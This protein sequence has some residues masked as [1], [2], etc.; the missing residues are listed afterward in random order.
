MDKLIH[1]ILEQVR[2]K[3]LSKAAACQLI[4]EIKEG[5]PQKAG[6]TGIGGTQ[7]SGN[8]ELAVI[9]MACRFPEADSP[10]AFWQN[11]KTGRDSITEFPGERWP[12][13]DFYSAGGTEAGKSYSKWGGFIKDIDKFA[14]SFFQLSVEEARIIDPQQRLFLEAALE[15]FA[16]AGYSKKLLW[17]TRTSVIVGARGATYRTFG[18]EREETFRSGMT[19]NITNFISA[20]VS[21]FFNLQGPSLTVDT[22]CS[23]SLV[24]VYYACQSIYNKECDMA[25][26]G[27]VELKVTPG[28]YITLSNAKALSPNGKSYVF[29]RRADGFVPGEGVG[30]VLIKP[31][32]RALEDGDS[33]YAVIKG[34]AVNNDGYTMGVTTPNVEGQKSVLRN[35]YKKAGITPETISCI[36]AHGTGTT[37]GDPIEMK[38]LT[39]VFRECTQKTGFCAVGSVKTNIGHLDTAAGIAGLIKVVL[40]LHH[41]QLPPTLN[42][43]IPNQRLNLLASPFYPN[44]YLRPWEPVEGVRRAGV[45]SFGFGGTN[46][47]IVLEE[48]PGRPAREKADR[49][50]NLLTLSAQSDGHLH[51]LVNSYA[52]HLEKRAGLSAADVCHTANTGREHF[53]CRLAVAASGEEDLLGKLKRIQ[54]NG[55]FSLPEKEPV[56]YGSKEKKKKCKIAFM[57]PGQGSQYPGMA[58]AL[59]QGQPVFREAMAECGD[60]LAPY[61]QKPLPEYIYGTEEG[62]SLL[63]ETGITQPAVFSVSYSLAKLWLSWGIKPAVVLGH[64]VGEYV[65]ACISGVFTLQEALRLIARRGRLMQELP[66]GGGMAVVFAGKREVL[67]YLSEL[68]DPER[69]RLSVAAE[70]GPKNTVVS[71]D[72]EILELFAGRL[73]RKNIRHSTLRVSHAFHSP[74]MEP[75]LEAYAKELDGVSFKD[76]KLPLIRNAD[77]RVM[78]KG[79][80]EKDYWLKHIMEPVLFETSINTAV[81]AGCDVLLEVGPG[82]TLASMVKQVVPPGG[83]TALLSTLDRRREE[84]QALIETLAQ[85]YTK[86]AD[87][88]F[89]GFDRHI[90]R[91]RVS[92]PAYSLERDSCWLEQRKIGA[93]LKTTA[94]PV[95]KELT[96]EHDD[97]LKDHV[98]Q[99]NCVLPGVCYWQMALEAGCSELAGPV[100]RL[101]EVMHKAPVKLFPGDAVTARISFGGNDG[102]EFR[103]ES[104]VKGEG[105]RWVE[106]A[107]GK[108]DTG[109]AGPAPE[110][111]LETVKAG[112]IKYPLSC[113]EVYRRFKANQVS[114]GPAFQS[115]KEIWGNER[116]ALARL[117]LPEQAGTAAKRQQ[118]FHPALMDG[119]LQSIIGIWTENAVTNDTYVPFFIE[120]IIFY[121][122]LPEKCYS[123][124]ELLTG[125]GDEILK[126]NAAIVDDCGRV[127]VKINGFTLKRVGNENRARADLS[128]RWRFYKPEW[129]EKS[130]ASRSEGTLTGC[131]LFFVSDD[132]FCGSV[133]KGLREKGNRVIA[134]RPAA[135]GEK[136]DGDNYRMNIS[137]PEDYHWLLTELRREKTEVKSYV[138]MLLHSGNYSGL[139]RPEELEE[140]LGMGVISLLHLVRAIDRHA[141]GKNADIRIVTSFMQQVREGET[142]IAPEKAPLGGLAKVVPGELRYLS[143]CSIDTD[144]CAERGIEADLLCRE[145][146]GQ[147]QDKAVAFRG[148]QRFVQDIGEADGA[149]SRE[150][151]AG[152]RERGV[153][154][155][156]G[157]LDGL[158]LEVAK[159]LGSEK[160]ARLV[161]LSRSGLAPEERRGHPHGGGGETQKA[162]AL[163]ELEAAGAELLVCKAD[164]SERSQMEEVRRRLKERGWAVQGIFHAAG[165]IRDGLLYGKREEEFRQVMKP[166]VRGAYLLYELFKEEPLEFIV[167]FSSIAAA[168]GNAGQGDYAAANSFMDSFARW[169]QANGGI[170]AVSINWTVWEEAGMA[171]RGGL[172]EATGRRGIRPLKTKEGIDA[173]EAALHTDE[174]QLIVLNNDIGDLRKIPE[175]NKAPDLKN[176]IKPVPAEEQSDLKSAVEELLI[177]RVAE[178]LGIGPGDI[179]PEENF[180]ELGLDSIKLVDLTGWLGEKAGIS[181]YP[182]LLFE[183]SNL[184]EL[185]G[186]LSGEFRN[187]FEQLLA[188]QI[189][190]N[191]LEAPQNTVFQAENT[192]KAVKPE[193]MAPISVT[194]GVMLPDIPQKG[195][196]RSKDIA[197]V[198][199]SGRFPKA[200]SVTEYWKNIKRGMEA[201][202]EPMPDR[203]KNRSLRDRYDL[204]G[205]RGGFLKGIDQFDPLFFNISPR[206]AALMDPQQRLFLE[207]AW[208]ALETA[209]YGQE[210]LKDLRT[211]VYAG[212]SQ[213]EYKTLW[214]DSAE[215]NPYMGL[216]N[217]L[218]I[219][220]NRV[221]YLLNLRGPSLTVDTACSSSLVAVHMACQSLLN[222]ETDLA[223]AGGVQI[224]ISPATF[225]IFK[226]A[227]ML[228]KDGRCK[229]FDNEADGYVRG[230]GV[231]AVLLKP[232][233]KAV[234]DGDIIHA[235]IKGSAV[236]HD[237]NNKVGLSAPNPKAQKEVIL[238]ALDKTGINPETIGYVEAHG[239]GTSLGDPVEITGLTQAYREYT[240]KK[241]FCAIGSVK[242]SI[243]HLEAAAGISGLVKVIM[244]LKSGLIPPTLHCSRPNRH[245]PFTDTP[246]YINDRCR[247]FPAPGGVR[248][249]AVSGFGF[250]GTNC[251]MLLEEFQGI[252][253]PAQEKGDIHLFTLSAKTRPALDEI[254]D[255]YIHTLDEN[256]ASFLGDICFSANTGKNHYNYRACLLA[257][258]VPQLRDRLEIVR[259][260]GME[261]AV[262]PYGIFYEAPDDG[263][264]PGNIFLMGEIGG[265]ARDALEELRENGYR[266]HW[267]RFERELREKTG[268]GFEQ[269]GEAELSDSGSRGNVMLAFVLQYLMAQRVIAAGIKP[270]LLIASGAGG[271]AAATAAAGKLD[272]GGAIDGIIN[273]A[274]YENSS[275]HQAG[276]PV[277]LIDESRLGASEEEVNKYLCK[278]KYGAFLDFCVGGPVE[279]RIRSLF[280]EKQQGSAMAVFEPGKRPGW[281]LNTALARL[282]SRGT[283]IDWQSYYRGEKFNRLALPV[284]PF[285][286]KSFWMDRE[287]LPPENAARAREQA[288]PGDSREMETICR[289]AAAVEGA[290]RENKATADR[291]LRSLIGRL[292]FVDEDDI[293]GNLSF[294]GYGIDS[295]AI[296]NAVRELEEFL[297]RPVEPSIFMDY[298][299]I[300]RM[301]E[302]LAEE[303]KAEIPQNADIRPEAVVEAAA[304]EEGKPYGPQD[305][306]PE[307]VMKEKRIKILRDIAN[308]KLEKG[309]G[310]E[311]LKALGGIG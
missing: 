186:Y 224:Y 145:L 257:D 118:E 168:F 132:D 246:F 56:F 249:A 99:G 28:P 24:A 184:K 227:G 233:E 198:G 278:G 25:L 72:K 205:I 228:A 143:S 81:N 159:F 115:I 18:S 220:A 89:T 102:Q 54:F 90:A 86:G 298:P 61:L 69:S 285:R 306:D 46:C 197:V 262:N 193:I 270:S 245:I 48:A 305:I 214:G 77:G 96:L 45:S 239:T 88:D 218:C 164:V 290:E 258:S 300:N 240:D 38:A 207:A 179:S 274:A 9:G 141:A 206:E 211:G 251:H 288:E 242:S 237:G 70:N 83:N 136:L 160:R 91:R 175:K 8:E 133:I 294:D 172:L 150:R 148:G 155:I 151:G 124:T 154:L 116:Q 138:H 281:A 293:D 87:I 95:Y 215:L 59:Y 53:D 7:I 17:G 250:G 112:L 47:H 26:A 219:I 230:E 221:S 111:A 226:L 194:G 162:K 121:D 210:R 117:E 49:E 12:T 23:S 308:G 302:Y 189:G 74:L 157:G 152:L 158:G 235:V 97:L 29:D 142:R 107:A 4:E 264:Q 282:Y 236:N 67:S 128:R 43:E 57:F 199:F 156:T 169:I 33:V 265:R 287:P 3:E 241:G 76:V 269:F 311:E 22:A 41:R 289:Q 273:P 301:S 16:R 185:A 286:K 75:M 126:A 238:E 80:L 63:D 106:N 170:R 303:Y 5:Y 14:A 119:A 109:H 177:N 140:A 266:R 13:S 52:E 209:G 78:N 200:A 181:L 192:E 84:R 296:Q 167:F 277:L 34:C 187:R 280:H 30:A 85:L 68:P 195:P 149:I 225:V 176:N 166:K 203:L 15:T 2:N 39:E 171:K 125:R 50:M 223:I 213:V 101:R 79:R 105:N 32:S 129:V 254:I 272:I 216:G 222:G 229:T 234:E 204:S 19:G 37:I 122:G 62:G 64:S 55:K 196:S 292:L 6:E 100:F 275:A 173:L 40:S 147:I 114:Y 182:T 188:A 217:S 120:E 66:A 276:A 139:S 267:E 130:P 51:N 295:I 248:R 65:A 255:G 260:K 190:E 71:G 261:G 202:D 10:E 134:V 244:M 108:L 299:T 153:Y 212:A 137:R 263:R 304:A 284:Y 11:L 291:F 92:L 271:R 307:M 201:V 253:T 231:G 180:L 98:V 178:L 103:I 110:I 20:R 252:H 82:T 183:Y 21:D 127:K 297:G 135:E 283:A 60:L 191:E 44:T 58:K 123:L 31:L 161:L 131:R 144:M 104:S 309:A 165:I 94:A 73:A 163:A 259:L 174:C 36:E 268:R 208:E 279:H 146:S 243:G 35:A 93:K 1:V 232:L 27:G 247:A 113:D 256:P 42:C 310:L